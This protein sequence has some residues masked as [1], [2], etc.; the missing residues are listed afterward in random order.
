M[1]KD[2]N[3]FIDLDVKDN[4]LFPNFLDKEY[5]LVMEYAEGGTLH[6]YLEENF[7]SLNWQ[8]KY[9][10]ALQLSNAIECLHEK[11]I[12]H[13]DL[14]SNNILVQQ[15]SIKLADFGLS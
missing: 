11:G 9:R 7:S 1:K 4:F 15:D 6:N 3:L 8:D 12:V 2:N 14:S 5:F 13:N 10:I